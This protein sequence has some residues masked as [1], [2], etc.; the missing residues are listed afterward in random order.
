MR[1]SK[2][3]IGWMTEAAKEYHEH[4]ALAAY[5][6][7]G[8]GLD[9]RVADSC[10]LGVVAEPRPEHRYAAGRLSIPYITPSGVVNI[11]FR[12]ITCSDKCEGHP[13]YFGVTGEDDRLYN[14]Q[15]LHDAEDVIFVTEGEIDAISASISGFPAVGVS[16]A[17]KWAEHYTKLFE[18][19]SEIV[20]LA[21]GDKA[22]EDFARRVLHEVGDSRVIYMPEDAD[23][24]KVFVDEGPEGLRRLIEGDKE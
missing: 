24:N 20:V 8:R 11:K 5:Y 21:D 14:V 3:L 10:L 6:L 23:V 4:V 7:Q 17:N 12:C 16:G 15:A 22:G 9:E 1:H 13:K 2:T 18:D 19:F